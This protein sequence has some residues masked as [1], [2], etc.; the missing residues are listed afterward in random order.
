MS[1]VQIAPGQV[2]DP[3]EKNVP[4]KG[5]RRDPERSPMQWEAGPAAGFTSGEPWLPLG[6]DYREVNVARE[7]ADPGSLLTLYRR[8]IALRRAEPALAVGAYIPQPAGGD[9]IAYL[10][11]HA[12]RQFL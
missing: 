3:W 6:R 9:L 10:R 4:G 2:Q 7:R 1:D 11:E 12:G 5:L 8:L